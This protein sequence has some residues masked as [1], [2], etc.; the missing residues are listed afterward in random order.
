MLEFGL[1]YLYGIQKVRL[2]LSGSHGFEGG[3]QRV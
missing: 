2:K 1:F 3:Q